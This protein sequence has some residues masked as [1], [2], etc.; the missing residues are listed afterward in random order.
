M[1]CRARLFGAESRVH[2][3]RVTAPAVTTTKRFNQRG[4][5]ILTR[6]ETVHGNRSFVVF[7]LFIGGAHLS[8]TLLGE[9]GNL[10]SS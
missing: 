3:W 10:L 7:L 9:A 8:G 6:R 2:E 5:R 1:T 4:S